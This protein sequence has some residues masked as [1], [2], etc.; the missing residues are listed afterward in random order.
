MVKPLLNFL[1]FGLKVRLQKGNLQ[2]VCHSALVQRGLSILQKDFGVQRGAKAWYKCWDGI[3][4]TTFVVRFPS[5]K[6][7]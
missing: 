7:V 3:S 4:T 5:Y 6:S 2:L 1:Y